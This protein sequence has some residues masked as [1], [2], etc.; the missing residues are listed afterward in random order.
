MQ[1]TKQ[2]LQCPVWLMKQTYY[3]PWFMNSA[4]IMLFWILPFN[5]A[6][7]AEIKSFNFACTL[8]KPILQSL[9]RLTHLL[10]WIDPGQ[11][12]HGV[13]HVLCSLYALFGQVGW[14][15]SVLDELQLNPQPAVAVLPLGTGNDLARTLNWG[16]V[17][18]WIL[19]VVMFW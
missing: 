8:S 7:R 6:K 17:W 2:F 13:H 3:Q 12:A 19:L 1:C 5:N 15:L 9:P 4:S 14:I 11:E 16:G 18:T 10:I